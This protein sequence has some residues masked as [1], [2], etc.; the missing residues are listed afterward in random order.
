MQFP[1]FV[2][3]LAVVLL[4]FL[5]STL[6]AA[7]KPEAEKIQ[8]LVVTGGHG[9][10]KPAFEGMFDAF[11][12]VAATHVTYPA[13]AEKLA[14]E[15]ADEFDVIVFYDMW[16]QGISPDQQK[17]FLQLLKRGI[18]VV[19]LHHAMAAHQNW[20]EYKKII[21]GRY[22]L[23][24]RKEDGKV[25]PKSGYA[26]GQDIPVH[27]AKPD[28]PITEGMED[29]T[30]HDET[31][32]NYYTDPDATVLLTTEHPKSDRELAWTKTYENSKVVY[33]ELGH[34][35]FAY[36]HPSYKK[37]LARS[38]RYVAG[39]PADSA[40]TTRKLFN[41]KDLS[42][43]TAEGN[44]IWEVKDGLLIGR[45]GKD[46]APGDLFT[47]ESFGDFELT[48]T[49]RVVW[50]A[51]SGVWYRYQSG[52]KAFQ[53]DILE[54]KSPFAL[55]GSLYRPGKGGP[56]IAINTDNSIIDRDGW[57]TL[58]IRAVGDRH[59]VRL[60]GE[61]TAD[62]RDDLSNRGKIGFQVHAGEQFGKM[63]IIIREVTIRPL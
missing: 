28:H 18:G 8:A 11:P 50:P 57:N 51:N 43:W 6:R 56:F 29:F 22:Y 26:H 52:A 20:P 25:L 16:A 15:L 39:R 33:I 9:Y 32:N 46:N 23:R 49:Y 40:T 31:Y 47:E 13:A 14:P 58:V 12:D 48:V 45:Q 7:D 54:Y 60:N 44:A 61:K 35:H 27:I 17:A 24:E 63:R 55:S 36:E 3:F 38:I 2:S 34:D 42:G 19:A 62:V 37:L 21:G 53:A 5:V 30:I 41:G 10:E 1:R 4:S 59:V